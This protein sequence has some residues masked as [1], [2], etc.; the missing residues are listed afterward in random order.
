[1]SRL[2]KHSGNNRKATEN[3]ETRAP[4]FSYLRRSDQMLA[5]FG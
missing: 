4:V 3:I 1:M 5:T 2:A